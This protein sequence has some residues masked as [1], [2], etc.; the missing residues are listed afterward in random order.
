MYMQ[1]VYKHLQSWDN[2]TTTKDSG[3]S[4]V[5]SDCAFDNAGHLYKFYDSRKKIS[6]NENL[7]YKCEHNGIW[8]CTQDIKDI[9]QVHK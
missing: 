2:L 8:V 9:E 3:M 7:S 5:I 6:D 4:W 1:R